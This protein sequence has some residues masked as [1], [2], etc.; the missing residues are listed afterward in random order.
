MDLDNAG[1]LFSY[2]LTSIVTAVTV[3]NL[4]QQRGTILRDDYRFAK[5]V[6]QD[7]EADASMDP[8]LRAMGFQAITRN[9]ILSPALSEYLWS[10][11]EISSIRDCM[12]GIAYLE[13]D[14]QADS[15]QIKFRPR[16]TNKFSRKWRKVMHSAFFVIALLGFQSPQWLALF[17]SQKMPDIS[18][19]LTVSIGAIV[20]FG[21]SMFASMRAVLEINRAEWLVAHQERHTPISAPKSVARRPLRRAPPAS[22]ITK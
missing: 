13:H 14:P 2:G 5:E 19:Y 15:S 10:L 9:R 12:F 20:V 16:Y 22:R 18:T 8:R 3:Y 6:M 7:I 21:A 17:H 1:K 11:Q 4:A